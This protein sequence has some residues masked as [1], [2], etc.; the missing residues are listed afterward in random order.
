M[1]K[2]STIEAYK[3][4]SFSEA[5]LKLK[6]KY[7]N[8]D[9]DLIEKNSLKV[10]LEQLMAFQ[11]KKRVVSQMT[12]AVKQFKKG[13]TLPQY[14]LGGPMYDGIKLAYDLAN[15]PLVPPADNLFGSTNLSNALSTN[16]INS[17]VPNVPNGNNAWEGLPEFPPNQIEKTNY[18]TRPETIL[19]YAKTSMTPGMAVKQYDDT[20]FGNPRETSSLFGE[21]PTINNSLGMSTTKDAPKTREGMSAYTPALIGQGISTALNLGI[22]AGGYDKVAPVDNPSV[23]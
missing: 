5:S 1:K 4:M 7:K 13:G 17:T 10:E 21:A 11:E 3:G 2:K 16:T 18:G 20:A 15:Q 22:L 19:G 6:E 14:P 9:T 23:P 12:D 8:A